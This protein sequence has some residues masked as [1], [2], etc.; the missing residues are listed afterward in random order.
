MNMKWSG[1]NMRCEKCNKYLPDRC[2]CNGPSIEQRR[3]AEAFANDQFD[4]NMQVE[5]GKY[6]LHFDGHPSSFYKL[7]DDKTKFR[8]G[9]P[10][11]ALT[12]DPA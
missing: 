5:P 7:L 2:T 11:F 9:T 6:T 4:V 3:N 1:A 10:Y 8:I 12:K